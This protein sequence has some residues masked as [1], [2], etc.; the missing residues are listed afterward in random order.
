MDA[1]ADP[2]QIRV[3]APA[4]GTAPNA[5]PALMPDLEAQVGVASDAMLAPRCARWHKTHSVRPGLSTMIRTLRRL[6]F[7]LKKRP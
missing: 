4:L 5:A 6:G 1:V 2:D 3:F 7:R